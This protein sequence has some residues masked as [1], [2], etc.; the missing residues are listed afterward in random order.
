MSWWAAIK[1]IWR[2]KRL[3][4]IFAPPAQMSISITTSRDDQLKAAVL[5]SESLEMLG[6]PH[7][8]IGGFAWAVLGS[9]RLTEMSV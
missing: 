7:A 1:M 9:S 8:F 2:Q 5:L 6:S 4:P 3:A